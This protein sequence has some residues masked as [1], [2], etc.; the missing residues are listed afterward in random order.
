MYSTEK[1]GNVQIGSDREK[2]EN[3]EKGQKIDSR[4]KSSPKFI[5]VM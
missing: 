5:M 2:K 3:K 1:F 4:R